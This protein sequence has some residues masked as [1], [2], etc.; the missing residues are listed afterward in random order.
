MAARDGGAPAPPRAVV[1]GALAV[2][3][4]VDGVLWVAELPLLVVGVLD[5][6]AHLATT[7]L[8][9]LALPRRLPEDV[10]L[11]AAVGSVA[12][13]LDHLPLL[14]GS[15]LLTGDLERPYSHALWTLALLGAVA[16]ALRRLRP[17]AAAARLALGAS[18]GLASHLARDLATGP[19]VHLLWPASD[20]L[21]R[22]PWP[23]YGL[24]LGAVAVLAARRAT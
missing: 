18:L 24:L 11:G 14:L 22:V 3:L 13:D 19:G 5:W 7:L 21:V 6:P 4:A 1:L 9:V 15:D 23:A 16:L 20:A 12:I 2:V 10:L 17:R 8:V